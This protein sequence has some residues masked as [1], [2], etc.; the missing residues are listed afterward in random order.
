[1]SYIVTDLGPV[2]HDGKLFEEGDSIASL[3]EAQAAPLLE[4][5]V[6]ANAAANAAANAPAKPSAKPAKGGE[7]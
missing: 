5:G 7:D 6:I 1:M 2:H 3:T 4:L